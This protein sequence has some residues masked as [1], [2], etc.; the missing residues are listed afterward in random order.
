M[1]LAGPEYAKDIT[2]NFVRDMNTVGDM[3][4]VVKAETMTSRSQLVHHV[5]HGPNCSVKPVPD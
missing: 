2:L 1:S 4:A 5:R 3:I